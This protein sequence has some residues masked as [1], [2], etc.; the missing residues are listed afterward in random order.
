MTDTD[1]NGMPLA[2][3]IAHLQKLPPGTVVVRS[4]WV[5]QLDGKDIAE[6]TIVLRWPR[7]E[8]PLPAIN[9]ARWMTHD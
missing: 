5:E 8:E 4:S 1:L 7:K 9:A 6:A 2:D 3:M